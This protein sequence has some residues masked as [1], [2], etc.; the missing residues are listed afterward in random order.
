M[1]LL[2]LRIAVG[3][4]FLVHGFQKFGMWKMQPS[5]QMPS[6]MLTIMRILSIA[7]PLGGLGILVG[8]LTRPA[9]IGIGIIM[10]GAIYLKTSKW[11]RKFTGDGG[12][13]YDVVL[14]AA[15]ITLLIAGAGTFSVDYVIF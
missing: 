8:F 2:V 14:L 6:N 15:V 4:V 9:S 11:N 10:L 13:E 12:W 5:E 7:E 3:I 1:D